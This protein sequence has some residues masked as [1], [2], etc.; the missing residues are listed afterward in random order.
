MTNALD[1]IRQPIAKF[2]AARNE[3]ERQI[4]LIGGGVLLVSML[5][6]LVFDPV[7]QERRRLS[8]SL[9]T[10]RVDA[11]RFKRDIAQIKGQASG[12]ATAMEISSLAAAAGL[13][14]DVAKVERRNEKASALHAKSAPWPAITSLL[15]SAQAQGWS[16]TRLS[17]SAPNSNASVDADVEWTR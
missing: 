11:A 9:P 6:A 2:W 16:L 8:R 7:W 4:L 12:P 13:S 3:R 17:V 5:Y 15:A 1:S 14:A 10:L